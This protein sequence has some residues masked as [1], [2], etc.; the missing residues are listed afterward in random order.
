MP[1]AD[2]S[3]A[4]LDS[5][6]AAPPLLLRRDFACLWWGQLISILGDRLNYLALGG[7]LL[8][9]TGRFADA[10]QSSILLG[11]L[12][13]VMLAPV[14]LFAPFVGPWV[15]R[16]NHRRTMLIADALR[17]GLVLLI[18]VAYHATHHIGTT[19]TIVFLLFTCNVFFLPAK[20]AITPDIVPAS[21]LL[22]ANTLLSIAGIAA[23]A[24]GAL[25]GGWLV[26]HFGWT[27]A[28]WIDAITYVVSV[29]SIALIR[30]RQSPRD[31]APF[32]TLG[33]YFREIG[34]GLLVVRRSAPVGLALTALAAVW[35]GG[36]FLHVAGNQH[37]QR[38]ASVPGMERIGVLMAVLGVGSG[39]GTWWV[40]AR[41]RN[42]PRPWMLGGGL[43]LAG[44]W[45]VAFAVSS[46]FAVF[47]ISAFLV[48]LCIAPAFILTE[49]L[50]QEGSDQRTRGRVF[51]IRDF[52]MR[53]A[54]QVAV[55]IAALLTPLFGTQSTLLV[56]AALV[57]LAGV[58]SFAWGRHAPELMRR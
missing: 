11:V 46:R 34:D 7:L 9:H 33:G 2:R 41:G 58:F 25:F 1:E 55:W 56:A 47:A 15:D 10:T 22:A 39:I 48:G 24:V 45:I 29:V 42:V 17:C 44:G 12:G 54:F 27:T 38:A 35:V 36:G 53:F 19:F 3:R 32:A 51:S 37:I 49:T 26:D 40:N 8:E 52:G 20:S 13:N 18:P 6:P 57:S 43:F 23:T 16:W 31:A 5:P 21:D 30:Y 50:L 14:L 28:L 4:T